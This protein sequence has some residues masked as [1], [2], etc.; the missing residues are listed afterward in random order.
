MTT[1]L[2]TIGLMAFLMLIMGIG[3]LSGRAL[4]GSCGGVGS[5]DCFCAKEGTPNACDNPPPNGPQVWVTDKNGVM[6][7]ADS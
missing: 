5:E 1:V 6:R 2:L 3:L 7:P 4:R